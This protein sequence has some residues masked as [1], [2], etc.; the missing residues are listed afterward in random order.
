MCG[1]TSHPLKE[2]LLY[3]YP[4]I[5]IYLYNTSTPVYITPA[6]RKLCPIGETSPLLRLVSHAA[7]YIRLQAFLEDNWLF[8]EK[9]VTYKRPDKLTTV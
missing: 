7:P 2:R 4:T 1:N 5:T 6:R 9:I 3:R 8:L